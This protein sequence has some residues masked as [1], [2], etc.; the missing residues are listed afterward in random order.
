VLPEMLPLVAEIVVLPEAATQVAMPVVLIVAAATLVEP[1][2]TPLKVGVEPSVSV[3]M[4][5]NCCVRPL[6]IDGLEGVTAIDCSAAPEQVSVVLPEM[7]PLVAEI[8]LLPEPA[9]QVA[10]PVVLI[11]ATPVLVEPQVTPLNGGVEPSVSVPAAVNCCVSPLATDGLGGVTAIDCRVGAVQVSVVLPEMVPLV[12]EIVVL[13]VPAT[14]VATPV[15]LLI[16]ATAMVFD[17]QV[18]DPV[19]F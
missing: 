18:T 7:L 13:P 14:Q 5:E 8:V 3:P 10:R 2:V 19:R 12:A 15:V 9:T 4:A 17:D 11:V 1:H 6:A 16:V